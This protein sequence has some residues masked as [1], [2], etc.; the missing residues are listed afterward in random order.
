MAISVLYEQRGQ[1]EDIRFGRYAHGMFLHDVLDT[2][3]GRAEEDLA[4]IVR[5]AV[6]FGYE[7]DEDEF[8]VQA[9]DHRSTRDFMGQQI[10]DCL[11][12]FRV[13]CGPLVTFNRNELPDWLYLWCDDID[14]IQSYYTTYIKQIIRRYAG[15]FRFW[16]C[17]A[18]T[19]VDEALG[20][21]EE[22]RLRL[23]VSALE[24]ARRI[25][26][27]TPLLVSLKQPW[28]EYL[29]RTS[30]DLTPLQFADILVRG[31]LG[32]SAIGLHIEIGCAAHSTLPRDLLEFNRMIEH[33]SMLGLPLVVFLSLQR[34]FVRGLTAGSVKG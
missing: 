22:Q 11:G 16:H 19:N 12:Q 8:A 4:G 28:G 18:G 13:G 26:A 3:V 21:T 31:D 29:G 6:T 7:S 34:Y 32:L 10:I 25:D 27:R 1:G 5:Q 2:D 17:A 9:F 23:T 20:L 33:W 15:E 24:S 14:A 30:M